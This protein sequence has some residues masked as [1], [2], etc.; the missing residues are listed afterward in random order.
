MTDRRDE[1]LKTGGAMEALPDAQ[2][3]RIRQLIGRNIGG[4]RVTGLL[5]SGGMGLVMRAERAEGD[6]ERTVAIKLVPDSAAIMGLGQRFQTER[7][8]LAS[9]NHP[10]IA[11]LYDAGET[12][13]GWPFLVME[14]VDGAPIDAYCRLHRMP[15]NARTML[16]DKVAEAV[17]FAHRR[18]VV[19]RDIKPSN[20]MVT[21][22]GSPK[23]LDFGIAK[24]M[25]PAATGNT[26]A[27]RLLTP[28]YA[29]PEQLLG[30]Q[31]TTGSDIYQLGALFLAVLGDEAPFNET[32]LSEAV[33]RAAA[34]REVTISRAARATIP[35]DLVAIIEKCLR[36]SPEDRYSDVGAVRSDLQHYLG[37][38]PVSARQ[39]A[40]LY[41]A[42]KLVSRNKAASGFAALALTIAIAGSALYTIQLQ[43]A[44]DLAEAKARTTSR[45]LQAMTTMLTDTYTELIETSG[46][47]RAAVD[48]ESDLQNEPLR[49]V[50][51]RTNRLIEEALTGEPEL[52]AELLL[53]QGMTN[54]ELNRVA[55]ARGQLEEALEIAT[56][57]ARQD[58]RIKA[59]AEL[60][61]L[62]ELDAQDVEAREL[63]DQALAIL[64]TA[65][66]SPRAAAD[67]YV[68]AA[69][70]EKNL[71]RFEIAAEYATEGVQLLSAL[72][73]APGLPLARAYAQLGDIYGRLEQPREMRPWFEKAMAIYE[74][75]EGPL[76]R[77][78][79]NPVSGLAWSH[80]VTGEYD[81][82]REYFR[83]EL[84]ITRANYGERHVRTAIAYN[85]MGLVARRLGEP[86]EAL[87]HLERG[88]DIARDVAPE[89]RITTAIHTNL[90][91]TWEELGELD[92]AAENFKAGLS[93][94]DLAESDPRSYSFLLNNYGSLLA[95][96]GHLEEGKALLREAVEVKT[97]VFGETNLSTA[98]S[99]LYLVQFQIRSGQDR[100]IA[101][102]LDRAA[103]A[104]KE[105]YGPGHMKMSFLLLVQA[106]YARAQG[107]YQR[108]AALL[109]E[110][111]RGRLEEYDE[112]HV[113]TVV[114]LCELA[115]TA[116]MMG[117]APLARRWLEQ[118]GP[119][120]GELPPSSPESIEAAVISAEVLAAE[121]R[122]DEAEK[123]R[124]DAAE[125]LRR[126]LPARQDLAARLA[127]I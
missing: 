48:P 122:N 41:R 70:L 104:Y 21:S 86:E 27:E 105:I 39:G 4:Y 17:E 73:G 23:L 31:I 69:S 114:A 109:E 115:R 94:D 60:I 123:A 127:A 78:L 15:V 6:F 91:N 22:D 11:Q 50:L 82:A 9:L 75:I 42:R 7:Q 87:E 88:L 19:H 106:Q 111:L 74:R 32:S 38:F 95:R 124:A 66:V 14:L 16:L 56:H 37:G 68:A 98:R 52:R 101:E 8:I 89:H 113:L 79:Q 46:P 117:D 25:D 10:G 92:A 58:L 71:G 54:R 30:H 43:H 64:E 3:E 26:R 97:R 59:L 18:L 77:G 47:R 45:L 57:S 62:A 100:D 40:G 51:A 119:G 108:A 125:R 49:L 1:W 96:R 13:E 24:L 2:A 103:A 63:L 61:K 72:D 12:D 112:R 93:R 80:A 102:L 65:P 5:G 83:R 34:R 55:E 85:N 121:R 90:G 29:S 33:T 118:A 36:S 28:N 76:Y 107:D 110:A 35:R 116:V 81:T 67:L 126:H 84:Q 99:M 53:V 20:V 120:I 44:R